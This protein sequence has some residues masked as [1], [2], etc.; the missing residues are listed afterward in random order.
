MKTKIQKIRELLDELE[1]ELVKSEP[2]T[3]TVDFPELTA[4]EIMEQCD[5]KVA[6]GKLLYN[7]DW[8]K[9][10]DFFTT[11]K[12][13]KGK[14]TI[15]LE[16][17]HKGKSWNKCNVLKGD[18]EMLNF[19]EVVYLLANYQEFRDLLTSYK[20]TWTS[21]R[22]SSGL[23]L[24]VGFFVEGGANVNRWYPR[25]RDDVALGVCFSRSE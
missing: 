16:L 4:K 13:R 25:V 12:T 8:Y 11:E 10:E 6:G 1:S 17:L 22:D 15:D 2:T 23:L 3:L 21:S 7:I 18:K 24:F 5:N 9:D 14:R 19:P 20:Y